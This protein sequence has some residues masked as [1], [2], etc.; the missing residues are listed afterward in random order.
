MFGRRSPSPRPDDRA[1][2]G[3][4]ALVQVVDPGQGGEHWADEPIGVIVAPGAS[5]L[6]GTQR[7]WTVAFDEPAYTTD[8]RGPFERATVLS[9]QLV[10]VEPAAG[11]EA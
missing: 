10:P 9:R 1:G 11:P 7:T 6:G 8:G 3:I 2:L 5:Q 4:G